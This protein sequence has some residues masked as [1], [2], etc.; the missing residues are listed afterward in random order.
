VVDV[1]VS[2]DNHPAMEVEPILERLLSQLGASRVTL[3]RDL[4][5]ERAFPVTDEALAPGVA[6]LRDE[7]TIDLR[8]QPVAKEVSSGRQVVQDDCAS[9]YDDPEFHRLRAVYG[10]L[11]AQIVTP[12]VVGDRVAGIV[13]VHQLG[14]PRRWTADEIESCTAAAAEVAELL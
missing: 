6:S 8:G 7:T 2:V 11:A 9:A 3:R 14:S 10:G 4:P 5:G 1:H 13:S 12:V